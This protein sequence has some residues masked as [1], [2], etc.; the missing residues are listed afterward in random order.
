LSYASL[1]GYSVAIP[2]GGLLSQ[3]PSN[4][5]TWF[6]HS[7]LIQSPH[8]QSKTGHC[9][10]LNGKEVQKAG[11]TCI[12]M[13]DSFCCAVES[14]TGFPG[15][16]GVKNPPAKHETQVPS[17]GLQGKIP[18][19][20]K[21]QPTPVLL[22]GKSHGQRSLVGYSPWGRK[23]IEHDLVTKQQITESNTTL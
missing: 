5:P 12:C 11:D 19:R 8:S 4:L 14:N 22:P 23:R 16:S 21:W 6:P 1:Q 15:E 10:D 2:R 17:M 20:R 9:G 18:W 3:G 7:Q 13:A